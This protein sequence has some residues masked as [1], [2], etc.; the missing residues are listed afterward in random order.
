M[1][2]DNLSVL[3]RKLR[4][5]LVNNLDIEVWDAPDIAGKGIHTVVMCEALCASRFELQST[6]ESITKNPIR[7][8][9]RTSFALCRVQW[10]H[11]YA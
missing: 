2:F 11:L 6:M 1:L 8:T 5:L 9:Q 7:T 4:N 3:V 10:K